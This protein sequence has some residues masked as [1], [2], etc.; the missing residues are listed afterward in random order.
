MP[1]EKEIADATDVVVAYYAA[2]A[3]K[4][5][6]TLPKL[7]DPSL[8]PSECKEAVDDAVEHMSDFDRVLKAVPDARDP[9][10]VLVTVQLASGKG[11]KQQLVRVKRTRGDGL[12]RVQP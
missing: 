12:W 11:P 10:S 9:E 3:A 5:C 8:T 2:L 1:T 6:T 4:D 7:V